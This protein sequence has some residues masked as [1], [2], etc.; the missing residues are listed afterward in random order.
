M[1]LGPSGDVLDY[2]D[3]WPWLPWSMGRVVPLFPMEKRVTFTELAR[4]PQYKRPPITE[5][6]IELRLEQPLARADVQR[7]LQR[8]RGEYEFSEDF[9]TYGIQVDPAARRAD[10][11][12]QSSGYKLSSPDRADVLL[13]TSAHMSCSR[14]APYVGWDAFRA[15]AEDHWRIW[16]RVIGY[17][18]ISRIGVRF[19]NRIDIPAARGEE[20]KVADYLRVRP[21]VPAV[22]RMVSYAMQISAPLEEDNCRLVINSGLVPSPLVDYISMLLDIDISRTGDPPQKDDEI[23]ALIDRIRAYK[24]HVFEESV[25]DKAR[26]LFNA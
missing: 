3:S 14:L 25:T 12:E 7:L 6:V 1:K 26:E 23:W 24:N 19:I 5:A 2:G 13:V 21:E 8:F 10:F 11:Q 17:R 20:V 4:M 15:R 18:K 22:K 16:K 9:V